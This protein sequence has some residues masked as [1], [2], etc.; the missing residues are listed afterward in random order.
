MKNNDPSHKQLILKI[1]ELR[2]SFRQD[3]SKTISIIE[4]NKQNLKFKKKIYYDFEQD[5]I[6]I[7]YYYEGFFKK[8]NIQNVYLYFHN[9][10]R[11]SHTQLLPYFI[12]KDQY[13]YTWVDMQPDGTIKN[14]YSGV[15][16]DPEALVEQDYKTIQNKHNE[17]QKLLDNREAIWQVRSEKTKYIDTAFKFNTEH[18]VPQSWFGA[19]EPMKGDLHHLFACQPE[20]NLKRSNFPY[21]DFTF[22]RPE[23]PNEQ[24]QNQCGVSMD[25]YFE[26]EYGKGAVARAMLYFILRYPKAIKKS[27][28][29][30]ID[31]SL[32]IKW[33][34][35]FEVSIYEK[36]RNQAIFLIQGN[37][38]PFIDFPEIAE[39]MNFPKTSSK[40]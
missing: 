14:I 6:D 40:R 8:K 2:Q 11:K 37:R 15:R 23:S 32:L 7:S 17:F 3:L 30:K 35:Q 22:Y 16:N 21:E 1:N 4:K 38:N 29:R 25:G 5:L 39:E 10:V 13:L 31:I 9:L 34:K 18:I 20:C 27:F 26:P 36:H 19:G 33:H 28:Y 12:S 24:I